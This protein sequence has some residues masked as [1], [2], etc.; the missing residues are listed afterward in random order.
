MAR[1]ALQALLESAV[2]S[3]PWVSEFGM[4]ADF[5]VGEAKDPYV[6]ACRAECMLAALVLHVEQGSV[7]FVDEDRVEVLRD[8]P[9]A[10]TVEAV[11]A[12]TGCDVER[13]VQGDG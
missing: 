4:S 8:A 13:W 9:D 10:A 11:R 12:A 7:N 5:G 3:T 6:R 2:S 1:G